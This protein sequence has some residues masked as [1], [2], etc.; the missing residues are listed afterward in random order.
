MPG[1]FPSGLKFPAPMPR[2]L[3]TVRLRNKTKMTRLLVIRS[4][5]FQTNPMLIPRSRSLL[6]VSLLV[7][8]AVLPMQA[9]EA[10]TITVRKSDALNVAFTGIGGSEGAATSA[11][12]QNDLKLAGWFALLQ[13]GLA[14][15]TVSGVSAGGVLQGKV[16]KG[17]ELVL[18]K[19][20]SGMTSFKP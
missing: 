14:S 7:F 13:P 16:Q 5:L 3:A 2:D 11:I 8:S 1:S 12:V 6:I 17:N 4:Q 15:F 9:T 20:Y 19:N 18:S 10:P